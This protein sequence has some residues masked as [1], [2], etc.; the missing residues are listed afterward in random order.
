MLSKENNGF[1]VIVFIIIIALISVAIVGGSYL[2]KTQY[3]NLIPAIKLST[4]IPQV[5]P[6]PLPVAQQKLSSTV[7]AIPTATPS[8]PPQATDL[9]TTFAAVFKAADYK[10]Y[11]SGK[12]EFQTQ[13]TDTTGKVVGSSTIR[14][15]AD[16]G[17]FYTQMG[18]LV[19]GEVNSIGKQQILMF[20]DNQVYIFDSSKKEY[21]KE[22]LNGEM[23]KFYWSLAKA[24][25]PLLGLIED[26]SSKTWQLIGDNEWQSDTTYK[27]PLDA[28]G[29]SV[30]IKITFDKNSGLINT[31][32]YRI[33]DTD[34]W[35]TITFVYEKITNINQYLVLPTGYKETTK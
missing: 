21:I 22:D 34:T 3:P 12:I 15:D 17:I 2:I 29:L 11:T 26:T 13:Q 27:T 33:N 31:L 32:S 20:K 35:Q 18:S 4:P 19:R 23:G 10:I 16:R 14:Y 9:I 25:L 28:K 24:G 30:K 8:S 1:T 7:T 5:S 6:S